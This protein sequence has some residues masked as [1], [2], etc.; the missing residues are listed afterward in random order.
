MCTLG[1][2]QKS[3]FQQV[4][5]EAFI[6]ILVVHTVPFFRINILSPDARISLGPYVWHPNPVT[7]IARNPG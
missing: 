7:I 5:E 3:V 2:R 1:K 6:K 4:L